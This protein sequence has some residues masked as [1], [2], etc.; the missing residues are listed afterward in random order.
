MEISKLDWM[1][2]EKRYWY[3]HMGPADRA[4][5]ER[6]IEK[7]PE[8]FERCAYDVV[9]GSGLAPEEFDAAGLPASQNRLYQ[10]KIDA[11]GYASNVLTI[12]ECKP[13]ASTSAVGQIKGYGT[14]FRRDYNYTGDLRLIIVTDN[15]MPE[16]DFLAK[17]EGVSIIVV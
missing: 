15:L 5:W 1:P 16:M 6:F 7:M 13:R 12:V 10:R 8:A 14:L 2:Y 4:I 3:P 9:V 11:L 17:N